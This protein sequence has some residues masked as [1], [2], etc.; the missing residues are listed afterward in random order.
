MKEVKTQLDIALTLRAYDDL[1][2]FEIVEFDSSTSNKC[3]IYFSSHGLYYPNTEEEVHKQIFAKN[4]Y[5][6]RKNICPGIKKAIFLRDVKKQW[7]LEGINKNIN[8]IEKLFDFLLG[9]TQGLQVICVGSSAGGYAATLI[10]CLLNAVRVFSFS[11]QF[12]LLPLLQDAQLRRENPTLVKAEL[13]QD[14]KQYLALDEFLKS[15]KTPV[16]YFFPNLCQQD[17]EQSRHADNMPSVY[18]FKF[19]SKEHGVT[20]FRMNL[21]DLLQMEDEALEKLSC[22]FQG[23]IISRLIFSI[24]I[25]GYRKTLNIWLYHQG[26][27]ILKMVLRVSR[28]NLQRRSA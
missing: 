13:D 5:E 20:C 24:K 17:V 25:S 9:E 8:S 1:N 18:K 4:R 27:F 19:K 22:L 14:L 2:N 12:S 11:G 23:R 6:W 3:I 10:G 28:P 7:Y 21:I 16:F 26:Y 15:N